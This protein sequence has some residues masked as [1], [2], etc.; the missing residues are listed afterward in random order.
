MLPYRMPRP[1]IGDKPERCTTLT[2]SQLKLHKIIHYIVMIL[3][4]AFAIGSSV[5]VLTLYPMVF[6]YACVGLGAWFGLFILQ[7]VYNDIQ[8]DE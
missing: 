5:Y 3:V 7:E 4:C 6:I 2:N 1:Q 8:I